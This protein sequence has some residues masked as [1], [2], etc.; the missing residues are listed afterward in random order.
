MEHP[1]PGGVTCAT[2]EKDRPRER[3]PTTIIR[4]CRSAPERDAFVGAAQRGRPLCLWHNGPEVQTPVKAT[5][6]EI[7]AELA[8]SVR[9]PES[10]AAL[11]DGAFAARVAALRDHGVL[12]MVLYGLAKV[13]SCQ[14]CR[15]C[16]ERSSGPGRSALQGL[17]C[18]AHGVGSSA[19]WPG[20]P[21]RAWCRWSSRGSIWR[22]SIIPRP[23]LR[24][25][26]DMDALFTDLRRGERAWALAKETG[27]EPQGLP[28]GKDPWVG[29]HELPMLLDPATGFTLE[30]Q[31]SLVY[32]VRDRRWARA[33]ALL[34][35][36]VSFEVAGVRVSGPE[37]GG[38]YR[39]CAGPQLR[40][41]PCQRPQ[42][43]SAL[44]CGHD[45]P[46]GGGLVGWGVAG[47]SCGGHRVRRPRGPRPGVVQDPVR[48]GGAPAGFGGAG[49]AR[50]ETGSDL[51]PRRPPA[52]RSRIRPPWTSCETRSPSARWPACSGRGYFRAGPTCETATRIATAGRCRCS[53]RSAG[54]SRRNGGCGL[55]CSG[56][57]RPRKKSRPSARR[58]T[59]EA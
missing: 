2:G 23:H 21:R 48:R 20:G 50:G 27:L 42:A 51:W 44:G 32:G 16:G 37:A 52:R 58:K 17:V 30:V 14:T 6:P 39:L 31:G 54:P 25:M 19:C 9:R 22:R 18:S 26:T 53:I 24:P 35:H 55:S 3:P 47:I 38:E 45:P 33:A 29:A 56:C 49:R 1:R 40:P 13:A 8:E 11:D 41:A 5:F 28:L 7:W 10:L 4:R 12:P 36:P 46:E 59:K 15:R 57:G 34:E 43:L